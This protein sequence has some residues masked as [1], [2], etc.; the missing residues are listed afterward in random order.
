MDELLNLVG[1]AGGPTTIVGLCLS[2]L[3]YLRKQEAGI[4]ADINGSLARL[5][6][7][8]EDKDA[9]IDKLQS[10]IDTLRTE[11][12]SHQDAEAKERLR[13]DLAEARLKELTDGQ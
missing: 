6:T 8:N 1:I 12:R 13:A 2:V 10:Q 7:E 9:E 4:R 3:F 11:R 5:T